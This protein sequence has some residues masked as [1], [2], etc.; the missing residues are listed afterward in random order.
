M[1]EGDGCRIV[2]GDSFVGTGR[3]AGEIFESASEVGDNPLVGSLDSFV[4][5]MLRRKQ[6]VPVMRPGWSFHGSTEFFGYWFL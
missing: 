1:C 2:S 4:E 5:T 3:G 6:A